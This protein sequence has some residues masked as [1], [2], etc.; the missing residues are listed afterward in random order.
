MTSTS[1]G[2]STLSRQLF[3]NGKVFTATCEDDFASAF[4]VTDGVIDWVG[5]SAE[6]EGRHA[7]DLGGRTVLPGFLDIHTHPALMAH[8]SRSVSCLPPVVDSIEELVTVLRKHGADCVGPIEGFGYHEA[9]YPE[10]RKPTAADLDLVS[11]TRPVFVRRC[12]GH[13]A[14]CNSLALR[15]AGIGPDTCDPEG[16]RFGR[17][18]E[19]RPNGILV[20]PPAVDRVRG[21]LDQSPADADDLGRLEEHFL[22]RGILGVNDLLATFLPEPLRTFREAA[23]RVHLPR[24]GLFYGWA[25][26]VDHGPRDLTDDERTGRVR[27]AGVKV[28]MD[29]AYSDRTAWVD[30]AYPGTCEH[31][32]RSS[33]D[34][35]LCA[36]V[37]WARRNG[38]QVAVHAMGDRALARVVE[39]FEHTEP[40]M[41]EHPSI[42]LE[43]AT[44][45]SPE[46]IDRVRRARM[47][48]GVVTHSIFFFAEYDSY[49]ENLTPGQ[50]AIAYPL[51]SLYRDAPFVAL[52][53]DCPATAWDGA[54]DVF[55]SIKA[56]VTRRSYSG[57]RFGGKEA[58][59][60]P[61]AVLLHTRR[62]AEV[63]VSAGDGQIAPGYE[64]NF[65]V[66]DRDVFTVPVDDI[67]RVRVAQT[68]M[69][70]LRVHDIDPAPSGE[71]LSQV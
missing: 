58:I 54:D 20:E 16:G 68:W 10:G 56:A 36:A 60:V 15:M 48:F 51:R 26:M 62:A 44:L 4:R 29:G 23:E 5:E 33:S 12:D 65:L 71:E 55:L 30:E 32:L 42:R 67:D 34:D 64:A 47:S 37:A 28:F 27:V 38:V 31:G 39:L 52:A 45:M 11:T 17:D 7:F 46:L 57:H 13:S 35:E 3:V 25:D 21:V 50:A 22:S 53:S 41:G 6:V 49:L 66:L 69:R 14:V 43:H 40:W 8:L 70:G 24:C 1:K 61:Q 18:H 2:S 19:G 59:S 9:R 63:S